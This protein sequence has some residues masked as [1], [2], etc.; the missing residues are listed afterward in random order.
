[1]AQKASAAGGQR[2]NNE[3]GVHLI[4]APAKYKNRTPFLKETDSQAL[5]RE[6]N[7]LSQAN[8]VPQGVPQLLG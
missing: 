2:L 3:T 4:S 7:K 8:Q 1:M 5:I 6:H